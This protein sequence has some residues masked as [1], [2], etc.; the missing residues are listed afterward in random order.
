METN[1]DEYIV[2]RRPNNRSGEPV[3]I[4]HLVITRKQLN[5]FIDKYL[6]GRIELDKNVYPPI[7]LFDY[8]AKHRRK[9]M[10]KDAIRRT[11]YL[12]KQKYGKRN[13]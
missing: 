4:I 9:Y 13:N 12:N 1:T 6:E 8:I 7:A 5:L 3:T 11:K 10:F 2:I